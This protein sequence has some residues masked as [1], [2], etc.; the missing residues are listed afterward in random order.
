LFVSNKQQDRRCGSSSRQPALQGQTPEFKVQCYQ[1]KKKKRIGKYSEQKFERAGGVAEVAARLPS[2]H[3]ILSSDPNNTHK[4]KNKRK[5]KV[6]HN[7][8]P[9]TTIIY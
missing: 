6:C 1:R 3:R 5:K 2:K 4:K 7:K 8:N 9:C